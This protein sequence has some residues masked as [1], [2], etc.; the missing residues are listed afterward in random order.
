MTDVSSA[1]SN[2]TVRYGT[3][4]VTLWYTNENVTVKV[5]KTVLNVFNVSIK[6]SKCTLNSYSNNQQLI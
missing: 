1:L 4:T 2:G 5:R 6:Y 3:T